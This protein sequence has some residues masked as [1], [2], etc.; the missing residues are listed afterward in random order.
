MYTIEGPSPSG[1]TAK[2]PADP[3]RPAL[4]CIHQHQVYQLNPGVRADAMWPAVDYYILSLI[5]TLVEVEPN[6]G[7][8]ESRGQTRYLPGGPPADAER[9]AAASCERLLRAGALPKVVRLATGERTYL[10]AARALYV[11]R[12]MTATS[13]AACAALAE[14]PG[15]IGGLGRCAQPGHWEIAWAAQ[16]EAGLPSYHAPVLASGGS[17]IGHN[18]KSYHELSLEA[19]LKRAH[20]RAAGQQEHAMQVLAN[21]AKHGGERPALLVVTDAQAGIGQRGLLQLCLGRLGDSLADEGGHVGGR[22][23]QSFSSISAL[24]LLAGLVAHRRLA[25]TMLGD[26]VAPN[27]PLARALGTSLR[28]PAWWPLDD[29]LDLLQTLLQHRDPGVLAALVADPVL[30][31]ALPALAT[32]IGVHPSVS[33][34]ALSALK[35]MLLTVPPPPTALLLAIVRAGM[36]R[37]VLEW[38]QKTF[39]SEEGSGEPPMI[40]RRREAACDDAQ[41]IAIAL[42]SGRFG[43][44]VTEAFEAHPGCASLATEDEDKALAAKQRANA[45]VQKGEHKKATKGYTM[46][47][48]LCPFHGELT[49][50]LRANRAACHLHLGDHA[51]AEVDTSHA[52]A[53]LALWEA[54]EDDEADPTR[55]T[56]PRLYPLYIKCCFRRATALVELQRDDDAVAKWSLTRALTDLA[57]CLYSDPNNPQFESLVLKAQAVMGEQEESE[58]EEDEEDEEGED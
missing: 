1:D 52:I 11:L 46:A 58:D 41:D 6:R 28:S 27:F 8:G 54:A 50:T 16:E 56:D 19:A 21:V 23:S 43:T 34:Q 33:P 36:C 26:E 25:Q 30:C 17:H 37:S 40:Q 12:Q 13:S 55:R 2:F 22:F 53:F 35:H 44:A 38:A 51:A 10:E 14:C 31:E 18:N 29:W 32:Y 47:L 57:A 15:A 7:A 20:D 48:S 4:A 5:V 24:S 39:A 3:A 49:S 42:A 9:E 45:H